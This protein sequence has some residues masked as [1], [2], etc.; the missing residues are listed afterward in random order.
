MTRE[1]RKLGLYPDPN[2]WHIQRAGSPDPDTLGRGWHA[3]TGPLHSQTGAWFPTFE[4]ARLFV[5][6]QIGLQRER[7][8]EIYAERLA[9][10]GTR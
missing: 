10:R 5:I 8:D 1:A 3:W 9:R 6:E 4:A 7:L 2:R